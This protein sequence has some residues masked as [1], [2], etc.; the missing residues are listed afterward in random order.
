VIRL[1]IAVIL[2][3][4]GDQEIMSAKENAALEP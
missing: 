3:Q 1:T 2:L 4:Q